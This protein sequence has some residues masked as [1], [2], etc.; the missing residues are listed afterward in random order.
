MLAA[1]TY[2]PLS[3]AISISSYWLLFFLLFTTHKICL[4]LKLLNIMTF[5]EL[6]PAAVLSAAYK[7]LWIPDKH[8][9]YQLSFTEDLCG[10]CMF[11]VLERFFLHFSFLIH[12]H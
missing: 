5:Q 7:A 12:P 10:V 11:Q 9:K 4:C 6:H 8:V 2:F 1:R 3:P